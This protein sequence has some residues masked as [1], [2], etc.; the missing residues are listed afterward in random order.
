MSVVISCNS[1]KI[2]ETFDVQ[3]DSTYTDREG[4]KCEGPFQHCLNINA[5]FFQVGSSRFPTKI[6]TY[7]PHVQCYAVHPLPSRDQRF[8]TVD[9]LLLGIVSLCMRKCPRQ[10]RTR[11]Y[12]IFS[13][14]ELILSLKIKKPK[15]IKVFY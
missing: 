12:V 3:L 13:F 10:G 8:R 5:Y 6:I 15:N 9:R 4:L 11:K 7:F 14:Y 1:L 2:V